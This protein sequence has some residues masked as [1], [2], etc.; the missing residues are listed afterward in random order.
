M[1][2]LRAVLAQQ[3]RV[4]GLLRLQALQRVHLV[5]RP[6]RPGRLPLGTRRQRLLLP[7]GHADPALPERVGTERHLGL[8]PRRCQQ[9]RPRAE[10]L[11]QLHP[12]P[13]RLPR[14]R[15]GPG[16][17]RPIPRERRPPQLPLH[18][19]RERPQALLGR[20]DDKAPQGDGQLLLLRRRPL[21]PLPRAARLPRQR[22]RAQGARVLPA[23]RGGIG[24][25]HGPRPHLRHRAA[26]VLPGLHAHHRRPRRAR[27]QDDERLGRH[28]DPHR[29]AAG[30]RG[31]PRDR[32]VR[33]A[34][35]PRLRPEPRPHGDLPARD[36]DGRGGRPVHLG[37]GDPRPAR[38]D[39]RRRLR[40]RHP[41][42]RLPRRLQQRDRRGDAG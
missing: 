42:A 4:A 9:H 35:L 34:A 16:A 41:A 18:P 28:G 6:T 7:R 10:R 19:P 21:G 5:R 30:K 13:G 3:Q 25:R 40:E 38:P 1:E 22:R 20:L 14:H 31:D 27:L 11:R 33:D 29:L 8:L 23:H 37:R 26:E 17:G 24:R 39:G 36:E 12:V 15:Q 2:E 32:H